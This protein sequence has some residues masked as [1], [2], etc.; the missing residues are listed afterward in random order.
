MGEKPQHGAEPLLN[1]VTPPQPIA[2]IVDI[3]PFI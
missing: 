1:D 2:A 3:L